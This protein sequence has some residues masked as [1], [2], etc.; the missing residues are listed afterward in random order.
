MN[1]MVY[2]VRTYIGSSNFPKNALAEKQSYATWIH[3]T[4]SSE[5]TNDET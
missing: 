1:R 5:V 4:P 3:W 2:S